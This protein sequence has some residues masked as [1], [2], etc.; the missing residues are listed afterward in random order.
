VAGFL[1]ASDFAVFAAFAGAFV[2]EE[3]FVFGGELGWQ[4]DRP[5]LTE[6]TVTSLQFI[7]MISFIFW[8]TSKRIL[9]SLFVNAS[10]MD[11]QIS[12]LFEK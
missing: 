4:A 3:L 9:L 6:R 7:A 11:E 10:K 5:T 1:V 12:D 2:E 8:L